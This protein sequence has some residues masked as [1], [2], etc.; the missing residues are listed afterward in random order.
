MIRKHLTVCA[1]A[2]TGLVDLPS[3]TMS[4]AWAAYGLVEASNIRLPSNKARS[5]TV[6]YPAEVCIMILFLIAAVSEERGNFLSVLTSTPNDKTPTL[7]LLP[8][9]VNLRNNNFSL[10]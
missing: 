10:I 7:T 9:I 6:P 3:V 4:I 1:A 2:S 5:V 8:D